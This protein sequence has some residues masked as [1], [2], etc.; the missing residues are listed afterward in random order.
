MGR[1]H[2]LWRNSI[3]NKHN[4][5]SDNDYTSYKLNHKNS[6]FNYLILYNI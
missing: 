4:S 6:K 3:V 2:R 5:R 1:T